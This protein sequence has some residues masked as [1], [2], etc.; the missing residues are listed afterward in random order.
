MA[1]V[2][3]L[4]AGACTSSSDDA[5]V[6]TGSS[7]SAVTPTAGGATSTSP[8]SVTEETATTDTVGPLTASARGVTADAIHIGIPLVDFAGINDTFG[9]DLNTADAQPAWEAAVAELN[10]R[11]G[12]LGREIVATYATYLPVAV[13]DIDRICLELTEDTETFVVM[14]GLRPQEGALCFTATHETPFFSTFGMPGEVIDA[15]IAPVIALE[16]R[17]DRALT[18]LVGALDQNG[19]LDEHTLGIVSHAGNDATIDAIQAELTALGRPEAVVAV[20]D[21]IESDQVAYSQNNQIIVERFKADGVSL[22]IPIGITPAAAYVAFDENGAEEIVLATN[23]GQMTNGTTLEESDVDPDRRE[24]SYYLATRAF[25]D[26][27]D[28]GH[29]PT[30]DCIE[31]YE[32]RTGDQANLFPEENPDIPGNIGG[33]MRSCQSIAILEA[34][35]TEAGADLTN[36]SL[37]AGLLSIVAF[38]MAGSDPGSIRSDKRDFPDLVFLKDY[39]VATDLWIDSGD[40]VELP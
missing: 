37:E 3:L 2:L 27:V 31:N 21:T 40:P 18:G 6:E 24:G 10:E 16:L 34:A 4:R 12:I 35:A 19:V 17:A 20:N 13:T 38:D 29:Q 23:N 5:G 25:R 7:T 9:V 30:I 22:V 14:G 1:A 39:D 8:P 36:E 28:Q 15:S 33:I 26:F 11:G 32:T